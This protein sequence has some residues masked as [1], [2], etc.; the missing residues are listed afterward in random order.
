M[1]RIPPH[2][3]LAGAPQGVRRRGCLV[4][5]AAVLAGPAL[6]ACA[7]SQPA[8]AASGGPEPRPVAPVQESGY[9]LV[10][11]WDFKTLIRDEAALRKEFF[12]RFIYDQG[13]QDHLNDEWS[14]YR[15]NGNHQ[16]DDAGLSLVARVAGGELKPGKVES[17]MLRSRWSGQHGVYEIRMKAP[18]GRGMWP[19]FWLNPQDATWPPEIDV[20]EIVNDSAEGSK[21][22]FHFLHGAGTKGAAVRSTRLD[23][24]WQ[25]YTPG[26]DFAEGYHVFSVE[27]TPEAV[28]HYVDDVLVT[29]RDFR[30]IHNNGQ[31]AGPAHVLVNLAVGGKWPGPP[32][33]DALPARLDIDYIRV[34]QR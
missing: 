18:R 9:R 25:F 14:R 28:R 12:T 23:K 2:P 27:W 24:K 1:N 3:P 10:K 6:T 29:D 32:S 33:P 11:N 21:R 5:G 22:S 7:Q 4:A 17:G 30:W 20:V 19:A 13:R 8:P 34:W 26:P 31:D 16:F 15:D